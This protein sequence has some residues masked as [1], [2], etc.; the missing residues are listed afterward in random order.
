MRTNQRDQSNFE[1]IG[2]ELAR[3]RQGDSALFYDEVNITVIA[4]ALKV[5]LMA[6]ISLWPAMCKNFGVLY[7]SALPHV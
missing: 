6:S 7:L 5:A 4:V 3:E 1:Y 2:S